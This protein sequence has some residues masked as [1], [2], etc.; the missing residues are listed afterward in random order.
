MRSRIIWI[1][2]G[3][4]ASYLASRFSDPDAEFFLLDALVGIG[5][6]VIGGI[7]YLIFAE[8]PQSAIN[9]MSIVVAALTAGFA[10]RAFHLI[11]PRVAKKI[12]KASRR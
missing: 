12:A 10:L 9:S 5:G 11:Y 3:T 7:G 2:A 4:L 6:A 1:V 8:S